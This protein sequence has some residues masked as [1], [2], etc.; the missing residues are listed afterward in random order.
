MPIQTDSVGLK[1]RVVEGGRMRAYR[2]NMFVMEISAP[3]DVGVLRVELL[4]SEQYEIVSPNPIS[5]EGLGSEARNVTFIVHPNSVGTLTLNFKMGEK[6]RTLYASAQTENPYVFGEPVKDEHLFF[7]RVAELSELYRGVT[8][9][10]KQNFLITGPRRAGKTS[11][12]IQLGTRLQDPFISL[13]LTPE[14]MGHEHHQVFR[15][16][17]LHLRERVQETIGEE[18]PPLDWDITSA[19]SKTPVDIFNFHFERDLKK[20]LA[21]LSQRNEETRVILLLDEATFLLPDSQSENTAHDT[22]QEFLRHLLQSHDRIACVLA[23]T[24][25]ILKITSATSPLYNIFSGIKLRGF[26][27]DETERLIR[28]P[29]QQVDIRFEDDAVA[30]IIEY[31]GCSPYYTQALCSLSLE[32]MYETIPE[33]PGPHEELLVTSL[34]VDA[35][36]RRVIDTVGYGL[37]SLWEALESDERE[38]LRSML[39]GAVI[40]DRQNRDAISRLV[41]MNLVKESVPEREAPGSSNYA[42]IKAKLDEEWIR[43]QG[44]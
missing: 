34:H 28:E 44:V 31:G 21:L 24:P 25:Q 27:D 11:L 1:V 26:T 38:V 13:L 23:G 42:V 15:S 7:G 18:L 43:E 32:H 6:T 5:I 40:V 2:S 41:D 36:I 22:R 19:T 4:Q 16:I 3:A 12:L 10:N 35:A 20:Y 29:A 33:P 14:K 37:K 30:R 39:S 8:K 17:L 9:R